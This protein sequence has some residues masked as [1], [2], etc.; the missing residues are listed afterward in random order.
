MIKLIF[1]D[2]DGTLLDAAGNLPPMFDEVMAELA[3]RGAVFCPAS[4]RQ[5]AALSYQMGAYRDAFIFIAE[6]GAFAAREDREL[7]AAELSYEEIQR[8]LA[9]GAAAAGAYPVLCGK[10]LAYVTA[11]WQPHL[12]NMRQYFTQCEIVDD[13]EK[14]AAEQ[15]IVKVAF[16]DAEHGEAD[17]RLYPMLSRLEGSV[18]VLLSSN[19]WIDV[20]RA[21]VN[22][23]T[24]VRRIQALYG[25]APE[26]CAAFGDYLNDVEM[27]GAVKYGFAME[28]AH[29]DLKRVAA[30]TAPPNTAYG[31]M[32]KLRQ[33]MDEGLI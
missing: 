12:D 30:G 13:L 8:V 23:G 32:V 7:F 3:R 4:G 14:T 29:P 11:R 1:C 10:R 17:T 15:E 31:V 33:L 28:N 9:G 18:Q 20:L 27:L 24:A 2:M 5:Y 19:Y 16:C 22:K 21:G 25:I 6:N 26:E